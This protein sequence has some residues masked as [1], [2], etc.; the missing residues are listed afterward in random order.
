MSDFSFLAVPNIN[1]M[2][3]WRYIQIFGIIVFFGVCLFFV[4][5]FRLIYRRKQVLTHQLH[6]FDQQAQD[7]GKQLLIQKIRKSSGKTKL[8]LFIEYLEKFVTTKTTGAWP[9]QAYANLWEL[10][11]PQWFTVKEVE[12]CEQILYA[13]K[14]LSQHLEI[15]LQSMIDTFWINSEF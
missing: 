11:L 15:K 5:Y 8:I 1:G 13:D 3:L 6:D 7:L 4:I 9:V 10:L 12:E 2:R 14:K